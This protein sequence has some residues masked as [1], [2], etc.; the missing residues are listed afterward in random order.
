MRRMSS[1]GDEEIHEE[2]RN[3]EVVE[4]MRRRMR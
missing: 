2:K 1:S 4:D 3:K